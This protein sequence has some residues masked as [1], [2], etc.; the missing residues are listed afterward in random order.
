MRESRARPSR[1]EGEWFEVVLEKW[2]RHHLSTTCLFSH[3]L[4]VDREWTNKC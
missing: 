2:A 4:D 3:F 1:R